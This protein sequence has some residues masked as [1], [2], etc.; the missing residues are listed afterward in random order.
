VGGASEIRTKQG[1]VGRSVRKLKGTKYE[2]FHA[3]KD[4]S[5]IWDFKVLG[6]PSAQ[7]KDGTYEPSDM[8]NQLDQRLGDY[9]DS[10]S[11]ISY[12]G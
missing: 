7:K 3:P 10:G 11:T 12:V 9:S 6:V 8:D 5:I 1:A 2:K 4:F